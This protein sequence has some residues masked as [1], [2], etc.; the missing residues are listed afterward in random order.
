MKIKSGKSGLIFCSTGQ[1]VVFF[2]MGDINDVT[3]GF[4][5][6]AREEK[7]SVRELLLARYV[8]VFWKFSARQI[9][10]SLDFIILL[11]IATW[12]MVFFIGLEMSAV[13]G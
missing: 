2:R 4:E 1:L 3:S 6:T 9:G 5:R 12:K 8:I 13:P 11:I 7:T 10:S